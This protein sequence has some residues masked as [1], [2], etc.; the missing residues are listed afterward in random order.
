M[1]M[2]GPPIGFKFVNDYIAGEGVEIPKDPPVGCSCSK[3]SNCY[4]ERSKCCAMQ[5]G[6]KFAYTKYRK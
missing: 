2:S 3:G 5:S 6:Y 1:D 4:D